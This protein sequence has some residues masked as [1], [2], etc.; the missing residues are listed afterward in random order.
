MSGNR[1]QNHPRPGIT[2]QAKRSTSYFCNWAADWT[3]IA[4]RQRN[5]DDTVSTIHLNRP[6]ESSIKTE[7][8]NQARSQKIT[9]DTSKF[10]I[11]VPKTH[12]HGRPS[13]CC[14][15][16]AETCHQRRMFRTNFRFHRTTPCCKSAASFQSRFAIWCDQSMTIAK[17]TL[18]KYFEAN[19]IHRFR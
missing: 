10:A 11:C 13:T 17:E 5:K 14:L 15:R 3:N 6:I 1:S 16:P 19:R 2:L 9:F 12:L 4:V 8:P 18:E 7:M